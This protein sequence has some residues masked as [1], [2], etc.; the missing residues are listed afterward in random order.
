MASSILIAAPSSRSS[1][2]RSSPSAAATISA[3]L[4]QGR[5]ETKLAFVPTGA[6]PDAPM[7]FGRCASQERHRPPI[8]TPATSGRSSASA[9]AHRA[10]HGATCNG[11][12]F[13][14]QRYI[15]RATSSRVRS[16]SRAG[17]RQAGR[18]N[19]VRARFAGWVA[20]PMLSSEAPWRGRG[21]VDQG[22]R[23][24]VQ[25]HHD[26]PGHAGLRA[27]EPPL[28]LSAM[29]SSASVPPSSA[30]LTPYARKMAASPG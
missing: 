3:G 9:R 26:R 29:T 19:P 24:G 16:Q 15:D 6:V 17:R 5:R 27:R 4:A 11:A 22:Q 28:R 7:R 23:Q 18:E 12:M 21:P 25:A 30:V 14:R 8:R 1:R 2:A 20:A 10:R 13:Q